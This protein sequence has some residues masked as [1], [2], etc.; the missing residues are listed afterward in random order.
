[1]AMPMAKQRRLVPTRSRVMA[2]RKASLRLVKTRVHDR[3]MRQ[4]HRSG[5]DPDWP[6]FSKP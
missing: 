1:M 2:L 5:E 3:I 4:F 6:T